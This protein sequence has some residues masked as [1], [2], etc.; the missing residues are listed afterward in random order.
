MEIQINPKCKFLLNSRVQV[1]VHEIR[2]EEVAVLC[3]S[4]FLLSE[5]E[6]ESRRADDADNTR[7]FFENAFLVVGLLRKLTVVDSRWFIS[8]A[9]AIEWLTGTFGV[10]GFLQMFKWNQTYI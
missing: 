1:V 7:G 5:R 9:F 3:S 10:S 4:S 6:G 2:V 8:R